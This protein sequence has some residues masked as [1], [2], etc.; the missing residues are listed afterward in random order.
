VT[1]GAT[2]KEILVVRTYGPGELIA[3]P[4]IWAAPDVIFTTEGLILGRI[5]SN[6]GVGVGVGVLVGVG[7]GVLVGVG[8]G[9]GV[10]VGVAV[11][12][13]VL[14]GVAVGIGVGVWV[15]VGVAVGVK[16]GA[17]TAVGTA[18]GVGCGELQAANAKPDTRKTTTRGSLEKPITKAPDRLSY[19]ATVKSSKV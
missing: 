18:V 11:G 10:L 7:V 8:V 4:E 5:S 2:P 6:V 12:V 19:G 14:V 3:T 15:W 9:V 1:S 17:G 16:V 13:G